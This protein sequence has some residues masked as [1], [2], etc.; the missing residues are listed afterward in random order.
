MSKYTPPQI[1][2][3]DVLITPGINFSFKMITDYEVFNTVRDPLYVYV[4]IKVDEETVVVKR[5]VQLPEQP[6]IDPSEIKADYYEIFDTEFG[7]DLDGNS[8]Y[9]LALA[10]MRNKVYPPTQYLI[11]Y[12]YPKVH[13]KEG[14]EAF[15][16]EFERLKATEHLTD[17]EYIDQIM[18]QPNEKSHVPCDFD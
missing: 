6:E 5:I 4:A 7:G 11:K 14:F 12:I 17:Q 2:F 9:N 18:F 1:D 16:R 8:C 3:H 13:T 10:F 15:I